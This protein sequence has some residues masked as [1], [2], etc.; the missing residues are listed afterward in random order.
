[1]WKVPP[2]FDP[3]RL[4]RIAS[5]AASLVTRN[6]L[7]I[8]EAAERALHQ[9]QVAFLT[10]SSIDYPE[11]W[12]CTVARRSALAMQRNAWARMQP[13]EEEDD[14]PVP[15][16]SPFPWSRDRLRC[17]IRSVLTQR[18]R[19]ALDAALT[20]RTTREAAR[21][22][23]MN[24]RDFRRYLTAISR[25][26]RRRLARMQEEAKAANSRPTCD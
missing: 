8:E 9:L 18:Q 26:A 11:A 14:M 1:M 17:A 7:V 13:I 12:L 4:L 10:G 22:C 16:P 2:A 19:D 3:P 24:P 15:E 6:P 5:R 21:T 20:C 23:H 25:R